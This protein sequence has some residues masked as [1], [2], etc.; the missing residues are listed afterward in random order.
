MILESSE[1]SQHAMKSQGHQNPCNPGFNG[2]ICL[3]ALKS[4]L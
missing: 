1:N 4:D 2:C 3:H